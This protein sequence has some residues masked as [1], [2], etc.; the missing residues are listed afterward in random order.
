M[1]KDQTLE[2]ISIG[3]FAR[4]TGLSSTALRRY[5]EPH[6]LVPSEVDPSAS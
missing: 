3:E 2:L 1:M 4:H 6:V 5:D